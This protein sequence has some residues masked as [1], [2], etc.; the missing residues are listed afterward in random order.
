MSPSD[1][2]TLDKSGIAAV[3]PSLQTTLNSVDALVEQPSVD[4]RVLWISGA[5][6]LTACGATLAA[7]ILLRLIS[8]A[9]H[10]AFFGTIST[11]DMSPANHHLGL[12]VVFIPMIGGFIVGMMARFG[13]QA[14][15]GHG[16][17]EAMEQVLF[18]ESKIPARMTFLKPISAAIAIGTGGPFGAEGPIIATGGALGSFLGQNLKITNDERK[19]LLAAGAAAG[20]TAIFAT[21]VAAVLIAIELL[22]FEFRPR[23]MIPVALAV[24]AA[25]ALR[26][27]IHGSG[28]FFTMPDVV[29]PSG[30]A[31]LAYIAIGA[32]MGVVAAVVSRALFAIEDLFSRLPIH[33]MWWPVLGALPVGIIGYFSPHTLGVGYENIQNILNGS[34]VGK[35]LLL[36]IFLKYISWSISLGS[37]TSGG[38]LAPLMTIGG[39]LGSVLASMLLIFFP[40]LPL[41]VRMAGLV[42]MAALFAG[43]SRAVLTS[44]VMAFEMTRQP[45]G[46]LPL[47]GACTASYLIA[48]FL[49]RHSIMTEKI[50]RRGA[51]VPS[52]FTADV[53]D[54]ILVRDRCS[55][56]VVTLSGD[57]LLTKALKSLQDG[58]IHHQGF[59]VVDASHRLIGVVTWRDLLT[60][61]PTPETKVRDLVKRQPVLIFDDHSLRAAVDQMVRGEVGRVVVVKREKPFE[62]C[63]M[64]TR[65]DIL[66]AYQGRLHDAFVAQKTFRKT[67]KS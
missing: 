2:G 45:L 17:P 35:T 57:E 44:I 51:R 55:K 41:D 7:E 1:T 66:A 54:K 59:P 58:R 27:A 14:I 30:L 49:S 32:V 62:V 50:A 9:T 5:A 13:S 31:L 52:E 22:L 42:G 29:A 18:N 56:P 4:R 21:P 3:A 38:T 33:W 48:Q 10:L 43:A 6:L 26:Y 39:G 46:R 20:M 65:S 12:W 11:A 64:L 16:I 63:G 8:L 53:L 15:R 19:T 34:L 60:P 23:S 36:L 37:G 24:V 67:R 40:N 47:L 28:S 25:A 61:Q